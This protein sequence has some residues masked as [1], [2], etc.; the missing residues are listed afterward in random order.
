MLEEESTETCSCPVLSEDVWIL[1]LI[2]TTSALTISPEMLGSLDGLEPSKL[3]LQVRDT[4]LIVEV[5][6]ALDEK[7]SKF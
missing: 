5:P 6:A 7:N 4:Y 2:D 3:I 1:F